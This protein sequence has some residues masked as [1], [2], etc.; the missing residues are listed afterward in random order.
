MSR[1][2]LNTLYYIGS[3]K[4]ANKSFV[5]TRAKNALATQL[6]RYVFTNKYNF[7]NTRWCYLSNNYGLPEG[8]LKNI[9]A[10]DLKCVYCHKDMKKPNPSIRRQDWA[11]IEH[12]NYLPP[13][14]NPKTVAICCFSCNAS[15]GK[16]K[17]EDWFKSKYCL[18]KI[19]LY[20][21]LRN[22]WEIF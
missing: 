16:K 7:S 21:Q 5:W 17:L 11:T 2:S 13:W 22:Q 19:L 1:M 20:L 10:R 15:R 8:E 6:R 18:K 14:N 9:R 12:M 3:H 4:T